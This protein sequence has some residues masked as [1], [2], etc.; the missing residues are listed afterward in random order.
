MHLGN[1]SKNFTID[2]MKKAELIGYVHNFFVDYNTVNVSDISHPAT[3]RRGDVVVM[4]LCT[5][6]PR[7]RTVSNETPNHVSVECQQDVSMVPLHDVLLERRD[8]VSK[9]HNNDV[10]LVH[11]HNVSNK[12]QTKHPTMSQWYVTKT[13]LWYVSTASH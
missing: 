5:S 6:Q 3:R 11:L 2:N 9:G 8:D 4:S 7:R 13:S 1:I 12:S 10:P